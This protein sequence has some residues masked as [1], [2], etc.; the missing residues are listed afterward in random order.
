MNFLGFFLVSIFQRIRVFLVIGQ[1]DEMEEI[2]VRFGIQV[3]KRYGYA[4]DLEEYGRWVCLFVCFLRLGI[5][6]IYRN[7][8]I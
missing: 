1:L 2:G 5:L 6:D 4:L 3:D 7:K 8:G